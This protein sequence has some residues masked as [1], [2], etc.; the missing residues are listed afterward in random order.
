MH[1]D[2]STGAFSG[3]QAFVLAVLLLV[4]GTTYGLYA[5]GLPAEWSG[6]VFIIL[7]VGSLAIS[8]PLYRSVEPRFN[9]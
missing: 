5:L 2:F 6:A 1:R 4:A 8:R 3:L 7:F 9:W